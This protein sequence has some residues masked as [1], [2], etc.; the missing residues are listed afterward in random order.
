[1][2]LTFC[3]FQE[4]KHKILFLFEMLEP[5]LDPAVFAL[6]S[7]IAIS[8][9]P[10][11]FTEKQKQTCMI[12]L[13]VIRTAVRKSAVLPSLESEWRLGTVAPRYHIMTFSYHHLNLFLVEFLV[14]EYYED[15]LFSG[16][17]ASREI[18]GI[19]KNIIKLSFHFIFAI[20]YQCLWICKPW[21]VSQIVKPV[22]YFKRYGV[23]LIKTTYLVKSHL[24]LSFQDCRF[25]AS[26]SFD[27][28]FRK[29]VQGISNYQEKRKM[30]VKL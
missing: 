1:M 22:V 26:S 8:D 5:F 30:F 13:N 2:L 10:F 4:V 3:T 7:T 17:Q 20:M 16:F 15:F 23:W 19:I 12:A 21:V 11:T 27:S 24:S 18:R 6:N 9:D 25:V 28:I 14:W 29:Q